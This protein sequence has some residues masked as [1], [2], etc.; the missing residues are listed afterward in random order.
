[1][2]IVE[3]G[4]WY[5]TVKCSNPKCGWAFPIG[6]APSPQEKP[7]VYATEISVECPYCGVLG[8]YQP[9]QIE[10]NQGREKH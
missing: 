3:P 2:A 6:E 8:T 5:F 1:M 7:D 9:E 4:K 10:R